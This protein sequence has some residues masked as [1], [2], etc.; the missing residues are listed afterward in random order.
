MPTFIAAAAALSERVT[1]E[2]AELNKNAS[3]VAS[4]GSA[5]VPQLVRCGW[6]TAEE[7]E[8][9]A[10]SLRDHSST[11]ELLGNLARRYPNDIGV[12]V[13]G[14]GDGTKSASVSNSTEPRLSAA[15]RS[16]CQSLGIAV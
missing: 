6:I 12:G 4:L 8:K 9:A 14:N 13:G 7:A 16:L 3:K 5:L 11:L 15:D 10:A 1:R 2:N